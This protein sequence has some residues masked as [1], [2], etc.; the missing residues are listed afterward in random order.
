[1]PTV[2]SH[3]IWRLAPELHHLIWVP[4]VKCRHHKITVGYNPDV[5]I[6]LAGLRTSIIFG[7]LVNILHLCRSNCMA[8]PHDYMGLF[9]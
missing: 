1:M 7:T 3:S 6:L 9:S 2:P 8:L 4:R 5:P